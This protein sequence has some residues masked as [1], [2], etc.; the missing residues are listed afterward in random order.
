MRGRDAASCRNLPSQQTPHQQPAHH[1]STSCCLARPG[2][3][4]SLM[5]PGLDSQKDWVVQGCV[6]VQPRSKQHPARAGRHPTTDRH[7]NQLFSQHRRRARATG[8]RY[9][10]MRNPA[11]PP[12]RA[13]VHAQHANAMRAQHT[14]ALPR[15][16][17]RLAR[18]LAPPQPPQSA[19]LARAQLARHKTA[20][21]HARPSQSAPQCR[22]PRCPAAAARGKPRHERARAQHAHTTHAPGSHTPTPQHACSQPATTHALPQWPATTTPQPYAGPNRDG[23][24]RH[25]PPA[26]PSH[27]SGAPTGRHVTTPRPAPQPPPRPPPQPPPCQTRRPTNNATTTT[28]TVTVVS[29]TAANSCLVSGNRTL[30]IHTNNYCSHTHH[31]HTPCSR[32]PDACPTDPEPHFAL[33]PF[34]VSRKTHRARTL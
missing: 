34:A 9:N 28:T 6:G 21:E 23:H 10:G 2:R 1:E 32:A 25:E 20:S 8:A 29:S 11:A 17:K 24:H 27:P 33:E 18:R 15:P 14:R 22:A 4:R 13:R 3:P 31:R 12:A 5:L 7:V 30:H 16:H 26:Q 19:A